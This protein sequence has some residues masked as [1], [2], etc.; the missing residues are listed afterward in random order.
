LNEITGFERVRVSLKYLLLAA[1]PALLLLGGVSAYAEDKALATIPKEDLEKNQKAAPDKAP[2]TPK[3]SRKVLVL[4]RLTGYGHKSVPWGAQALRILG[5]KTG[6]YS[7]VLSNDPAMFDKQRLSQ[8]DAVVFNNNCGNPVQDPQRR[9]NLLEF[10]ANGRG[11]VGIHC[12]AHIA[13]PEFIEVLGGWSISH[14]WNAGSTITLKIEYPSHPLTKMFGDQ[15]YQHTDEIFEF[16]R[17]SRERQRVLISID[18]KQ[19]DMTLPGI[20]RKDGDFGLAWIRSHGKGRVFYSEFGHQKDVYW[21]P[22]I[23]K[24]YLAGIQYALGDLQADAT[25]NSKK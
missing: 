18:T 21:H 10:V 19:T 3:K 22:V 2:A 12:A 23:L 9:K 13:W 24:H 25:P 14:P 11:L 4:S 7:A 6:A 16:D 1:L 15:K 20:V 5:E 8:F 17:Y